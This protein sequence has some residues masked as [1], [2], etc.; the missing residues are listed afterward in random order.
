M[1]RAYVLLLALLLIMTGC[2]GKEK[3]VGTKEQTDTPALVAEDFNLGN[4]NI[5]KTDKG[6]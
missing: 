3:I 1:K 4:G 6:Y 2:A 5:F